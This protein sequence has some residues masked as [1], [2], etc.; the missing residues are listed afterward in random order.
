[1]FQ[2][3]SFLNIVVLHCKK[4]RIL[5]S[6]KLL[7]FIV[8]LQFCFFHTFLIDRKLFWGMASQI[9]AMSLPF[10]SMIDMGYTKLVVGKQP[11]SE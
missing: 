4:T 7:I 5:Y 10:I 1:M 9:L 11:H 8:V 2:M 3:Y 6:S